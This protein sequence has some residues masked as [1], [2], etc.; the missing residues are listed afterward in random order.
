[1][2]SLKSTGSSQLHRARGDKHVAIPMAVMAWAI[3]APTYDADTPILN[4]LIRSGRLQIIQDLNIL[5]LIADWDRT[6]RDYTAFAER[7]R[8]TTDVHM[9]P[10]LIQRGD[11]GDMLMTPVYF[12]QVDPGNYR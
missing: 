10:A 5:A 9:V 2:R 11:I 7:A 3:A 12:N 4:G 8:R 1:M 6:L